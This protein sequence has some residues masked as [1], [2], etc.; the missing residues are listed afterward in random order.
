MTELA[1][2]WLVEVKFLTTLKASLVQRLDLRLFRVCV[3]F[4]KAM[5]LSRQFWCTIK[6][7]CSVTTTYL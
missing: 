7:P 1:A 3:C 5:F 6:D 2:L 4:A